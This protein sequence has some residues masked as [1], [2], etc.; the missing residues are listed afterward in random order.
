MPPKS[1]EKASGSGKK[2]AKKAN[3]GDAPTQSSSKQ[4]S[5]SKKKQVGSAIPSPRDSQPPLSSPPSSQPRDNITAKKKTLKAGTKTQ[6][7]RK[8]STKAKRRRWYESANL[9]PSALALWVYKS[10][11]K[12]LQDVEKPPGQPGEPGR[13]GYTV[14]EELHLD[15]ERYGNFHH[16]EYLNILS[17]CREFIDLARLPPFEHFRNQD[18][19]KVG[20]IFNMMTARHPYLK[21]FKNNW[22]I[23]AI[24]KGYL[25]GQRSSA[26]RL[27]RQ[28]GEIPKLRGS[29]S[30]ESS[31]ESEAEEDDGDQEDDGLSTKDRRAKILDA[32]AIAPGSSKT[33]SKKNAARSKRPVNDDAPPAPKRKKNRPQPA[34]VDTSL[35]GV[36]I[37]NIRVFQ[38]A[39]Y[40]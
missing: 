40:P 4:S 10:A 19:G 29:S 8:Q 3:G 31:D 12:T 24:I 32:F 21:L 2:N 18:L 23:A 22:P 1:K 5:S 7:D 28:L 6:G 36:I 25:R 20:K 33:Q 27:E 39:H 14:C 15:K 34:P 37:H 11:S 9:E 38:A 13:G 35:P 16:R 30:N 26:R 17:S